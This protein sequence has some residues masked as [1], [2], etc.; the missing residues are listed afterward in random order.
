MS[1]IRVARVNYNNKLYV[2]P[3]TCPMCKSTNFTV[4]E[5][6]YDGG[7]INECLNCRTQYYSIDAGTESR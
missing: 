6:T 4:V 7:N 2:V 5:T 1:S 3:D